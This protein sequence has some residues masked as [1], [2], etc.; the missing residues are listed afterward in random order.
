[1]GEFPVLIPTNIAHYT[2]T[3]VF[4]VIAPLVGVTMISGT[5][6]IKSPTVFALDILLHPL[7][8]CAAT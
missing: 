8:L 7:S 4:D 1:M 3:N 2:Y 6:S 5:V